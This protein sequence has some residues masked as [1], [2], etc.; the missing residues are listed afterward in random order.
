MSKD[1]QKFLGTQVKEL[2]SKVV[3]GIY[4]GR[5]CHTMTGYYDKFKITDDGLEITVNDLLTAKIPIP[6]EQEFINYSIAGETEDEEWDGSTFFEYEFEICNYT[7]GFNLTK[8]T[9]IEDTLT[10]EQFKELVVDGNI[11]YKVC[12]IDGL[13][14]VDMNNCLVRLDKT[15]DNIE[16]SSLY[17]NASIEIS[18]NLVDKIYNDSPESGSVCYRIEFNNGMSDITIEPESVSKVF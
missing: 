2:L 12:S 14:Y 4:V 7:I 5:V 11:P 10:W 1:V 3:G 15:F 13:L 18:K 6:E 17:A 9:K 8:L 16:I